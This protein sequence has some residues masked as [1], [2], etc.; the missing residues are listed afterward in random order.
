VNVLITAAI[1]VQAHRLKTQLSY[2]RILLGDH[3]ELPAF[4]LASGSMVRLPNPGSVAYT[5]EMLALCLDN[6]ISAVYVF[7]QKEAML[8]TEA[9]QLFKEYGIDILV[10]P[11]EI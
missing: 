6:N 7:R 3:L 5:H 1:S 2:D 11:D 4:M 8:L 10:Q 9:A